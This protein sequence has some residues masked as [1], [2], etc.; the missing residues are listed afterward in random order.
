MLYSTDTDTHLKDILLRAFFSSSSSSS[1]FSLLFCGQ[2]HL[3]IFSL[4]CCVFADY[5]IRLEEDDEEEECVR[6][7]LLQRVV[8]SYYSSVCTIYFILFLS[9]FLSLVQEDRP[10]D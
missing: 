8:Q 7:T 5:A 6:V 1:F 10:T 3:S 9:F 4:E 2:R